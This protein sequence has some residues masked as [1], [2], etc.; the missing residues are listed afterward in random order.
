MAGYCILSVKKYH[1]FPQL[2][3]LQKHNNRDIAL[4]NVDKTLSVHNVELVAH[5]EK[6]TDTW[7]DIVKEKE[8]KHNKKIKIRKNAVIAIEIVTGFSNGDFNVQKWAEKS[9]EWIEERFGEG[10]IIASTLH[11]D[12]TSPHLHTEVVPITDDGRLCAKEFINGRTDLKKMHTSYAKEMEEFG[13]QRGEYNSK[14]KKKQLTD[15]YKSVKKADAASL[16]PQ[17]SGESIEDYLLRMEEYCKKMKMGYLKVKMELE[18]SQT[19]A[20]TR[21]AQEFSKYTHAV[22]LYEDLFVKFDGDEK[23]VNNRLNAYRKIENR[24]PSDALSGLIQNL[25]IKFENKATPL[26]NWAEKGK[27]KLKKKEEEE[28]SSF[29]KPNDV[30]VFLEPYNNN[31]Q[32]NY[33]EDDDSFLFDDDE[34]GQFDI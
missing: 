17:M 11:L 22:S 29:T 7:H 5:N 10:N 34:D 24:T 30:P 4:P 8:I 32:N 23:A 21:V 1:T 18:S 28:T 3:A 20:E 14:A 26:V 19:L 12:E 33:E 16:P 31:E 6:Y 2:A 15:F 9:L 25:L 13:L 27:V